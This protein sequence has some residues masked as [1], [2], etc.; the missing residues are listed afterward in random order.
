M[1]F[2]EFITEGRNHPVIVVDVQPAYDRAQ[3]EG[4]GI[5]EQFSDIVKFVNNQTIIYIIHPDL[6]IYLYSIVQFCYDMP[7][8]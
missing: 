4:R 1:R 3:D 2:R 8:F 6:Y 7:Y 5:N